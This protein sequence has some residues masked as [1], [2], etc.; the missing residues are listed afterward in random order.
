[1]PLITAS[2]LSKKLAEGIDALVLDVKVGRGAFMKTLADARTL[3]ESLVRVGTLSG[4]KITAFLTSMDEP[5]GFAIGNALETHEA[6]EVLHGRGPADLVECTL[7]LGAEML[8]L[9]KVARTEAEARRKLEAAIKSGAGARVFEQIVKAQGGDARVVREPDRLPRAPHRV[10]VRANA[11]GY[12]TRIDALELGLAGVALGAGRT[13]ADQAVDPVVGIVLGK[14][15]GD[16]V[17]AGEVLATVHVRSRAAAAAA[18]TRIGGA[19][20]LGSKRVAPGPL[21]LDVV[22]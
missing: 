13:R 6:I 7:V 4:K 10:E 20:T 22:R 18:I 2:I 5:L 14:K 19:F 12:V 15:L 3:A 21:V 16:A 1:V 11:K 8:R 17:G 9:G